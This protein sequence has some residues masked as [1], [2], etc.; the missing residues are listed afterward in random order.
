[1]VVTLWRIFTLCPVASEEA[2]Y[3]VGAEVHTEAHTDDQHVHGGDVDGEP[4]PVT[5]VMSCDVT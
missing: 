2:V 5:H 4:P 1:M 3:Y